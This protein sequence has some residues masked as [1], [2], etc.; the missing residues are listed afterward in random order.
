VINDRMKELGEKYL[1]RTRE[2]LALL[3]SQLSMA[4]QGTTESLIA[5]QQTAHRISGSGAMLGFKIISEAASQIERIL[6]RADPVPT[7][8]EWAAISEHL[9]GIQIELDKPTA[10]DVGL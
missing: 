3:H 5:M 10:S 1:L 2:E 6:R 9:R 8:R 4:K 7:E